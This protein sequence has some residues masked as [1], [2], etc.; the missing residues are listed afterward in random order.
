MAEHL[1]DHVLVVKNIVGTFGTCQS[2][3]ENYRTLLCDFLL[4]GHDVAQTLQAMNQV[5]GD[6][7]LVERIEVS[8]A[9]F[10]VGKLVRKRDSSPPEFY[11]RPPP[12]LA[13][14]HAEL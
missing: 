10:V 1:A 3:S 13:C 9:E 7:V 5:S 8:V 11:G 12:P 2:C 4:Q 6:A 14:V